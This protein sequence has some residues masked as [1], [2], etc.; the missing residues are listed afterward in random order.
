MPNEWT[1][2]DWTVTP[3]NWTVAPVEPDPDLE[4]LLDE[5]EAIPRRGNEYRAVWTDDLYRSSRAVADNMPVARRTSRGYITFATLDE[6]GVPQETQAGTLLVP[7]EIEPL[8]PDDPETVSWAAPERNLQ[9]GDRV[10]W[11]A[12]NNQ[13]GEGTVVEFRRLMNVD[14][15]HNIPDWVPRD[16]RHQTYRVRYDDGRITQPVIAWFRIQ[17]RLETD[18]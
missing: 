5:E 13:Y 3:S 1:I 9:V 18:E 16:T 15:L 10:R 4:R 14:E 7:P 11:T 12:V 8:P 6:E 17:R 2:N